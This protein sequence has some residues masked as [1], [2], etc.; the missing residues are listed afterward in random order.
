MYITAEL[1]LNNWTDFYKKMCV[2][3]LDSQLDSTGGTT[4]GF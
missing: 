4:I 1:L 3:G 2:Y